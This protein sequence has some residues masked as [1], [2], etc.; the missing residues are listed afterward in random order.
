AILY[1][2][3]TGRPPIQEA[4]AAATLTKVLTDD[5]L[6][7]SRWLPGLSRD[8][9]TICLKCLEKDPPRRYASAN[10][11]AEDLRRF[12]AGEPIKARPIGMVERLWRWAK[13]QPL[14]AASLAAVAILAFT[15]IGTVLAYDARLR[16]AFVQEKK[17]A[18]DRRRQLIQLDI[19]I[20]VQ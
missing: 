16:Q 8:L 19:N 13:R 6:P 5:P 20:S 18:E 17:V 12:Q 11:L 7:P 3:L 9:D 1:E 10:D 14:A 4:I 15:L 2:L